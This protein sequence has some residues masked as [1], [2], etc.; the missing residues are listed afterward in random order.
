MAISEQ[1]GGE[2]LLAGC[3]MRGMDVFTAATKV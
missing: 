3:Q 1:S 2:V